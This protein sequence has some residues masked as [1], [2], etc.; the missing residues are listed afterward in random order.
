DDTFF[1]G[2]LDLPLPIGEMGQG[3]RFPLSGAV[4]QGT[5]PYAYAHGQ[6]Y[7][8]VSMWDME[9]MEDDTKPINMRRRAPQKFP[10]TEKKEFY[11]KFFGR[12]MDAME[13]SGK[14]V[15]FT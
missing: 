10:V 1:I 9:K 6:A 14:K 11:R 2:G 3:V 13:K 4:E 12:E 7:N 8:P 5:S 15:E